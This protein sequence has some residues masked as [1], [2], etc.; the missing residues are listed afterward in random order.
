VQNLLEIVSNADIDWE[1]MFFM[2]IWKPDSGFYKGAS[3]LCL[4]KVD[5][6]L[7]ANRPGPTH[8]PLASLVLFSLLRPLTMF[9]Y[10]QK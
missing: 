6:V 8:W 1:D 3:T 10:Q 9:Y 4:I 5:D 2:T 7:V